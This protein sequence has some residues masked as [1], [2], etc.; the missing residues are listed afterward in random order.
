MKSEKGITLISLTVY[1][2]AM[3]VVLG[4]LAV[5]SRYFYANMSDVKENVEPYTEY[6]AFNSY[7][8]DEI[9]HEG[10]QVL[11]CEK[12]HIVFS[13]GVQYTFIEENEGIYRDKVKICRG[14]KKCEFIYE[15]KEG[16]STITVNLNFGKENR[17]I[18]YTLK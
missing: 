15:L 16:K 11:E 9:N 4:I 5:I 2:I 8:T 10:I 1:I 13:N 14:V 6:T 17:N 18:T 12:D 3:L 7:F